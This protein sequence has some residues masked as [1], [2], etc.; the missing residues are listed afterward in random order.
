MSVSHYLAISHVIII[1]ISFCLTEILIRWL[2]WT[3]HILSV[4]NTCTKSLFFNHTLQRHADWGL[5]PLPIV[6]VWTWEW[7]VVGV[8]TLWCTSDQTWVETSFDFM[9]NSRHLYNAKSQTSFTQ[10]YSLIH[11]VAF[12]DIQIATEFWIN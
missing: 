11:P 12:T 2:L 4:F 9:V 6:L 5:K 7:T 8:F 3:L 10:H 1:I